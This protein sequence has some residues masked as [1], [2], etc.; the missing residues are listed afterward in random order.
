MAIKAMRVTVLRALL[1]KE[2]SARKALRFRN[3]PF[4]GVKLI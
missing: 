2:S 4:A 3:F 1:T